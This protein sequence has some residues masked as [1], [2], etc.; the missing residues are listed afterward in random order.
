MATLTIEIPDSLLELAQEQ[1]DLLGYSG[2]NEFIVAML[3]DLKFRGWTKADLEAELLKSINSGE[4]I[5][6]DEAFW[7][8][9]NARFRDNIKRLHDRGVA[10]ESS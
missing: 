4:P 10:E 2:A 1:A 9:F 7:A 8:E 5:V 6:A 3:S